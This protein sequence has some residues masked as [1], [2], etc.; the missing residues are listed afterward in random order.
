MVFKSRDFH[1]LPQLVAVALKTVDL[2]QALYQ[3]KFNL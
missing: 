2:I 3:I 1:L